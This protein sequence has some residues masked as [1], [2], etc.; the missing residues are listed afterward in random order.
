VVAWRLRATRHQLL[1]LY[2]SEPT[3]PW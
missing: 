1:D 3:E 2:G